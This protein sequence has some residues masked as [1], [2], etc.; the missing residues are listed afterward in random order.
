MLRQQVNGSPTLPG[1]LKYSG[2]IY[3][4][5]ANI[6]T[7]GCQLRSLLVFSTFF[8]SKKLGMNRAQIYICP[9]PVH[10]QATSRKCPSSLLKL[11]PFYMS[12][13]VRFLIWILSHPTCSILSASQLEAS[14]SSRCGPFELCNHNF[15]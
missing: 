11:T 6:A 14:V 4:M 10:S 9:L 15:H 2:T 13:V 7:W 5:V 8:E 1:N 3:P 12:A